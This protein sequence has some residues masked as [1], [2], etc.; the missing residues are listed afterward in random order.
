VVSVV[1]AAVKATVVPDAGFAANAPSPIP[2]SNVVDP[3]MLPVTVKTI[4]VVD[5]VAAA[6]VPALL[7]HVGTMPATKTE[8]SAVIVIVSETSSTPAVPVASAV[9]GTTMNVRLVG[10]SPTVNSFNATEVNAA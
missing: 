8:L 4:T 5:V 9:T 7:V 3:S 10:V 2:H 6:T 1:V